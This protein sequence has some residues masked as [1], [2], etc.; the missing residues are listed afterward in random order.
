MNL[1]KQQ[2]EVHKHTLPIQSSRVAKNA[3]AIPSAT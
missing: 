3:Q 2:E 1:I